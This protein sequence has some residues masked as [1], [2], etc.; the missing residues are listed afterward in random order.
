MAKLLDKYQAQKCTIEAGKQ[1]AKLGPEQIW[2]YQELL[3][4]ISVLET[5]QMFDQSAPKSVDMKSLVLH[6]QMIDA[7]IQN[8][9]QERR[10]GTSAD[11][12]T[13]K[14]RDTAHSSL[15]R[16]IQDYRRRFGSF[17]PSTGIQYQTDIHNVII[18]VIT[19]WIEYRNTFIMLN[20]KK[21][22]A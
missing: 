18:S 7:Y 15:L 6:Y 10:S 20:T 19:V 22:A 17:A 11:E 9:T 2:Q 16:V 8:L 13:Q 4:R 14:Q 21:E 12:N 1:N 5:F 3:Y